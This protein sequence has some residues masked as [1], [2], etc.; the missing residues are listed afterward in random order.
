MGLLGAGNVLLLEMN[1][2]FTAVCFI[3]TGV[4]FYK[5]DEKKNFK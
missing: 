3:N 1:L 2:A 5:I 4:A